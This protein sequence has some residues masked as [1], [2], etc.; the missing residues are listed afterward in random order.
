MTD[1]AKR[2]AGKPALVHINIRLPYVVVG[3]YKQSPNYTKH[4]REV[5]TGFA[6]GEID[7]VKK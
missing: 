2:K 6:Y 7:H 3:F 1:K 4:M 5:L